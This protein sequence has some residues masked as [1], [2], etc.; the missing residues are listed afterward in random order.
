VLTSVNALRTPL[1]I[2]LAVIPVRDVASP[3]CGRVT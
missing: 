3:H 1:V 2:P